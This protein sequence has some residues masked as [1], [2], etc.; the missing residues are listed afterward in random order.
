MSITGSPHFFPGPVPKNNLA[1][2]T[3]PDAHY[4]GLLECPL[5]TRIQKIYNPGS[6]GFADSYLLQP[7]ICSS[8]LNMSSCFSSPEALGL[9]GVNFST[10]HSSS[11][12]PGC[13]LSS[14]PSG[15]ELAFNSDFDSKAPCHTNA[16]SGAKKSLVELN[17]SVSSEVIITITGPATVW[18]G[19]G[20]GATLMADM[21]YTIV[22][23]GK[24]AVTERKLANHAPGSILAT[25]VKIVSNT[26]TNGRRT[27]VLR[28][29]KR[30][31]SKDHFTF[32]SQTL[33]IDFINAIG[34]G[35]EFGRCVLFT[36]YTCMYNSHIS[37]SLS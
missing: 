18:F 27:V 17:L 7:K 12:P 14:L 35:Q 9:H 33:S 37:N 34:T 26:V 3:G 29:P 25:S 32:D 8:P 30:G 16:I 19:V 31:L 4:S 11:V 20:L 13:S 36:L 10:V 2:L 5:T 23:D 28:R 22:V 21:P 24:G 15:L 6:E 1:P